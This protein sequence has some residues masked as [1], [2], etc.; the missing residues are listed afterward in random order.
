MEPKIRILGAAVHPTGVVPLELVKIDDEELKM[1][2]NGSLDFSNPKALGGNFHADIVSADLHKLNLIKDDPAASISASITANATSLNNF[3]NAEG[4]LSIDGF[5][6]RN[7]KGKLNMESLDASIINDKLMQKRINLDCDFLRFEMAGKM[8][9]ATIATAFKQ[10]V[11]HYVEIPQWTD[12]LAKFEESGKS[13]DQDFIV[14]MT[15]FD[16]KPLTDMFAPNI[17]VANNTSLK[18]TFT[19]RS[20][21]LNLT[22]RSK[23]VKINNIKINNIECKSLSSPRRSITRFSVDNIILRDSTEK[24]PSRLSLDNMSITAM[25]QNDSIKAN[26]F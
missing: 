12:D 18:G 23:Y 4:T 21:S 2:F 6:F 9:F 26:L 22:M 17:S 16:T 11:Q 3:N 19:S 8:D 25:L 5:T 13:S 20:N 24:E 14:N 7:S 10:Y 15:V 1:D